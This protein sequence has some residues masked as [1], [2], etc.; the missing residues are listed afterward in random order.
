MVFIPFLGNGYFLGGVVFGWWL[1]EGLHFHGSGSGEVEGL[2]GVGGGGRGD[3]DAVRGG[4]EEPEEDRCGRGAAGEGGEE[5]AGGG[6]VGGEGEAPGEAGGAREGDRGESAPP[7]QDT[8][9]PK[10]QA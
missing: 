2:A 10:F 1:F 8:V 9:S 3:S 6:E 7:R 5:A 4:E